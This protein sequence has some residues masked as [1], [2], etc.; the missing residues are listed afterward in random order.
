MPPKNVCLSCGAA[1]EENV[2]SSCPY[3][4]SA[5]NI[6][7]IFSTPDK[8]KKAASS[9]EALNEVK[10]LVRKG[11]KTGATIVASAKFGLNREATQTTGEQVATDMKSSSAIE[12]VAKPILEPSN[13]AFYN[14]NS[15]PAASASFTSESDG[16]NKTFSGRWAVSLGTG[17]VI[18]ICLCC[19]CL[20]L[21]L[22]IFGLFSR[23]K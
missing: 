9:A 6:P 10:K 5:L 13:S 8:K 1:L 11:D 22:T 18:L 16:T 3:C 2:G 17:G 23:T 20:P 7:N 19:C 12:P 21:A 15:K 4:G 14:P